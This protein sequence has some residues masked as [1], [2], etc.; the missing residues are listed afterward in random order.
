MDL[1]VLVLV[2]SFAVLLL[3]NVPVAFC[4]GIAAMLAFLAMGGMPAFTA[5]AHNIATGI[6]SFALL[7]IPFFILSGLF[8]GHGGIA[9]RLIDFA[10]VLVGRFRGGLAYVNVLTCMLFG[11]ISGSATAAVSSVGGFMVP[12]MN[13]MGY[14]RDFNAAVTVTAATTGL[15]IPPSNVMIVYSLATGGSVS[16]AAIF[17]AGYL[18]GILVGLGLLV[19]SG[20][21]SIRNDYGKGQTF[22]FWESVVR[23]LRAIPAMLLVLIVI[24]GILLGWFTPTEASAVAVLYSFILAVC[25]YREVKIRDLP[26]ILLQCGIMTS[27]VFLLIGTSMAMAWVLA[28]ENV[29]QGISAALVSWTDNKA[30]LLLMMNAILLVVGMFMDMTPAILIFTPIFLPIAE[31]LGVHPLHLGIIMIMN[32]CIGLCTP[33]VGTCL[34]L[35]CGIAETTV[36]K[37]M[38]PILPFFISLLVTLLLCTFVPEISLWLP[39]KLGFLK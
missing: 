18:P 23:F 21:I 5:V 25:V 19:V 12:L 37:V 9:R 10:N 7:A 14:R 11:A 35:G 31:K 13:K 3:L 34:F 6:D 22:P 29:P 30:L 36:T 4:M 17:M 24:G 15:L 27:V 28:S 20:V 26:R 2:V 16:I 32:L 1:P 38:R 33:P 39:E 8:M